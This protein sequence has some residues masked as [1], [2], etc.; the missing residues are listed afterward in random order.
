MLPLSHQVSHELPLLFATAFLEFPPATTGAR[1]VPAELSWS[2]Q[3]S[4]ME[5]REVVFTELAPHFR[6][7]PT[8]GTQA[9]SPA[10]GFEQE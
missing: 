9:M 2:Y 4:G 7:H 8:C 10:I 6:L 3:R 5:H 1:F